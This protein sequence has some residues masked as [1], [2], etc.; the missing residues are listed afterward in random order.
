MAF[1]VHVITIVN[2]ENQVANI[3]L[4]HFFNLMWVD[5]A[6]ELNS[7]DVSVSTGATGMTT[8]APKFS[9]TVRVPL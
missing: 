4:T 8:V 2:V 7:R 6:S 3:S 9:D 1:T 5:F